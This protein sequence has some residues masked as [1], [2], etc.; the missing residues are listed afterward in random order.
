MNRIK[1]Y[2]FSESVEQSV[3]LFEDYLKTRK[4]K[5]DSIRQYRIMQECFWDGWKDKK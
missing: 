3:K 2:E 1:R 4:Y 5:K